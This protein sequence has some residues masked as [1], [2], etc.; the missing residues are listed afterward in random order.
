MYF[1][2]IF[3]N[4]TDFFLKTSQISM[5]I[6]EN[7]TKFTVSPEIFTNLTVKAGF[8]VKKRYNFS[9]L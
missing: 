4:F 6:S 7:F 2:E 9:E 8:T 3:T 1:S 5:Y